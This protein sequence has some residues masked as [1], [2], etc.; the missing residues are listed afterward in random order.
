MGTSRGTIIVSE[1]LTLD[2]VIAD[3]TG[4]EGT[5][6]GG[7]FTQI[8]PADFEAWSQLEMDESTR[9]SALLLGGRTYQ[10]F[11]ERWQA[12]EGA[13]ADRLRALPKY[14]VSATL[15]DLAWDHTT[16][17]TGEADKAVADLR[18]QVE[19]E[20]VVYGSGQLVRS[21]LAH[22][23]VDELRLTVFPSLAGGQDRLFG[24][25]PTSWHLVQSRPL[26]ESLVFSTYR[27]A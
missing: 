4:D 3:P 12:R 25:G 15:D 21:L 14:D 8:P 16:V 10:W 23:L 13:W 11:A 22:D 20:I 7:W 19:G 17:L 9:A 5:P 2:G 1:N 26:G 18:D 6:G 24:D 27:P